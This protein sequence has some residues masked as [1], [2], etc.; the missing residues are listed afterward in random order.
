MKIVIRTTLIIPLLLLLSECNKYKNNFDA[1]GSFEAE[2]TI[3]S[4]EASG[5]IKQ[6]AIEEGQI[7]KAGETI[8]YIDSTQ[9]YLRKKQAEAQINAILSKKPNVNV[10]LAGLQEQL[11]TA[12]F[13]KKRVQ[14]LLKADAAT[15]KQLDDINAQIEILKRQI[16]AQKSTLD[17]ATQGLGQETTPLYVQIEQINDQLKKCILINPLNG[18]VITKFAEANEMSV[19]GKPLYKIADLSS[20]IMRAYITGDQLAMVKLNQKVTV[21]TDNGKGGFNKTEGIIIRINDKAEFTP[22]TI[23]T[24]NERANLVY[25]IKVKVK[26]DGLFKLACMAK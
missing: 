18:T 17:I 13:E 10:Q 19:L 14:N 24:K 6:F 23:Q 16:E 1:S 11:K 8:G 3:I 2:E 9:L 22:K 12:E 4:S 21:S 7:L 5:I 15:P 20:L 26:N 25:A